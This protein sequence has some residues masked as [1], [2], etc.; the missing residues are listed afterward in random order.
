M[1]LHSRPS[2]NET[3]SISGREIENKIYKEKHWGTSKNERSE[4]KMHYIFIEIKYVTKKTILTKVFLWTLGIGRRTIGM[5][6]CGTIKLS[7]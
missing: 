3:A 6:R 2:L 1:K 5:I 7:S 4:N